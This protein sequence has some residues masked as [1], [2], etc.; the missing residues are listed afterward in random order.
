MKESE[1]L[2]YDAFSVRSEAAIK[3][4]TNLAN[5]SIKIAST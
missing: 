4:T 3:F 1:D 2:T 5:S